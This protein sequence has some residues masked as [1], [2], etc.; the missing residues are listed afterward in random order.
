MTS[1]N[2]WTLRQDG[3]AA[4]VHRELVQ[5]RPPLDARLN[6]LLR[7]LVVV[8][9]ADRLQLERTLLRQRHRRE[10]HLVGLR[11]RPKVEVVLGVDARRH[12]DVE[13]Q[14]LEKQP[15]QLVPGKHKIFSSFC[16]AEKY[17]V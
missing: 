9:L 14:H 1:A 17:I 10:R 8:V 6:D 7:Q 4:T 13:L 16:I 12:V 5:T 3:D 2:L 15:L 11:H